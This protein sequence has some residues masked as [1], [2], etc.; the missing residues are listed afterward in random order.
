MSSC[1]VDAC[2]CKQILPMHGNP[3]ICI[4]CKHPTAVHYEDDITVI[5]S[6]YSGMKLANIYFQFWLIYI[7]C[8]VQPDPTSSSMAKI[9]PHSS[10]LPIQS[11]SV[12]NEVNA[13]RQR[14]TT[15][16]QPDRGKFNIL[17]TLG[18][19]P[20]KPVAR[21]LA[22]FFFP[23]G[24]TRGAFHGVP[25]V[26]HFT[27][28]E[29]VSDWQH[30]LSNQVLHHP[31]WT[32]YPNIKQYIIDQDYPICVGF[33]EG[34][35]N[36]PNANALIGSG[37]IADLLRLTENPKNSAGAQQLPQTSR[38][39]GRQSPSTFRIAYTIFIR[40]IGVVYSDKEP[41]NSVS[42]ESNTIIKKD[43]IQS[44][45]S[46]QRVRQSHRRRIQHPLPSSSEDS[47]SDTV[48]Q[49]IQHTSRVL[50]STPPTTQVLDQS[51]CIST[52]STSNNTSLTPVRT[53]SIARK[54]SLTMLSPEKIT[55]RS[56]RQIKKIAPMEQVESDTSAGSITEIDNDVGF[57]FLNNVD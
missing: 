11:L 12:S 50:P 9:L 53:T 14:I 32:T 39:P 45:L 30:Y 1:Q 25:T 29:Q 6:S 17:T 18:T 56:T 26:L 41:E 4:G 8:L 5:G 15:S 28:S 48:I 36:T 27:K 55:I 22:L 46:G 37:T 57:Q 51:G 40:R 23:K 31:A 10:R 7:S 16:K 19:Q 47:E 35:S 52:P 42:L 54:R 20:V 33:W 3:S 49:P 21:S 2:T 24:N 13:Q 38:G 43:P 44:R 34:N